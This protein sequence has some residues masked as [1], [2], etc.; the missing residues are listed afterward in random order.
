M[1]WQHITACYHHITSKEALVAS[2]IQEDIGQDWY[3]DL[4]LLF[5]G[6]LICLIITLWIVSMKLSGMTDSNVR[7]TFSGVSSVVQKSG[8]VCKC[9]RF[10]NDNIALN[11]FVSLCWCILSHHYWLLLLSHWRLLDCLFNWIKFLFPN[12]D[13][14]CKHCCTLTVLYEIFDGHNYLLCI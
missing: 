11:F 1:C 6:I 7:L 13:I 2:D 3:A 10:L 14:N 9:T 4:E 5:P 8:L 12:V